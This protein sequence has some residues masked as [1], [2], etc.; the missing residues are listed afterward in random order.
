M[1]ASKSTGQFLCTSKYHLTIDG[2]TSESTHLICFRITI[3]KLLISKVI[4]I[5]HLTPL[6][7]VI[8]AKLRYH[9]EIISELFPLRKWESVVVKL[10]WFIWN[11]YCNLIH[12]SHSKYC[13]IFRGNFTS[14]VDSF[15]IFTWILRTLLKY[16][17]PCLLEWNDLELPVSATS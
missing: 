11:S 16:W 1:F 3:S 6:D 4:I 7:E 5:F 17:K 13:S 12:T 14:T 10:I 9:W 15:C 8:R 2:F